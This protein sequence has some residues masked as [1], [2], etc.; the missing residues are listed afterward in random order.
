M[1]PCA[2]RPA[3]DHVCVPRQEE[4]FLPLELAGDGSRARGGNLASHRIVSLCGGDRHSVAIDHQGYVFAWGR[5]T[6]GQLGQG[7]RSNCV[8]TP[9]LIDG[10]RHERAV[11]AAAGASHTLIL[12]EGGRVYATGAHHTKS[13]DASISFFGVGAGAGGLSEQ[14]RHMIEKSH[15]AY[16]TNTC[17]ALQA[18]EDRADAYS[19]GAAVGEGV[20]SRVTVSEHQSTNLV[21]EVRATPWLVT[22]LPALPVTQVAGHCFS[23][24]PYTLKPT[25]YTLHPNL[26]PKHSGRGGALFF[27]GDSARG[28]ALHVG[29]Q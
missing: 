19:S 6:E 27:G 11:R 5:N 13:P 12:T 18:Q 7:Y 14:K 9:S 25:P 15:L 16:F 28:G 23:P 3:A 17:D 10:L 29:V 24:K 26:N 22:L 1:S 8:T 20:A 2:P 4:H 21:R